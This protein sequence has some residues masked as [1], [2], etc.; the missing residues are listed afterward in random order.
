MKALAGED[1]PANAGAFEPLKIVVEEGS[2]LDPLY[3]AA[4]CNAN[5]ITTQRIV[6]VILGALATALPNRIGAACS[7]TMH[8]VNIGIDHGGHYRTFVETIG[9]GQGG[10]PGVDGMSGVHSHMSNTRNTPIEILE[11]SYPITIEE[12]ALVEDSAGAGR[13]RGGAGIRR[14]YRLREAAT[15]TLSSDRS[16]IGPWGLQGGLNGRPAMN[17]R[18]SAS[19]RKVSL[20][21][22]VSFQASAGERLVLETPGGGGFGDPAMRSPH[23]IGEDIRDGVISEFYAISQFGWTSVNGGSNGGNTRSE[24]EVT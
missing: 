1:T 8:L 15:I 11:L 24:L 14:Q 3:P 18:I 17:I 16:E 5:I 21:S 6:D 20:S 10:L 2:L 12:Y 4:V 22:K 23:R 7:G 9:G 19:G 13:W